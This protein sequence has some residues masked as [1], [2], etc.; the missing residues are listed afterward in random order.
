MKCCCLWIKNVYCFCEMKISPA[1]LI[2]KRCHSHQHFLTSKCEW[3]L[4]KLGS[5][6][7][8]HSLWWLLRSWGNARSKMNKETRLAPGSW[9]AYDRNEYSDSRDL[10]LPIH[11]MPNSLPWYWSL[12]FKL[13]APSVVLVY[14]LT[15]P[16]ALL[17]HFSQSYWD[18]V[19]K[20]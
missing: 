10:H 16:L 19:S 6:G 20:A 7:C 4:P 11:R 15:S 13:S 3:R 1:M 8:C 18:A 12:M 17:E 14:S 9:G 2:N 5:S